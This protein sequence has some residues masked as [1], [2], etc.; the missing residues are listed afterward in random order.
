MTTIH[1][2]QLQQYTQDN[3]CKLLHLSPFLRFTDPYVKSK[4]ISE[5]KNAKTSQGVPH[6]QVYFMF[7][8]DNPQNRLL[9]SQEISNRTTGYPTVS[10]VIVSRS[11][12]LTWS[13]KWKGERS[14]LLTAINSYNTERVIWTEQPGIKPSLWTAQRP[15]FS[16]DF[17]RDPNTDT[18]GTK[19]GKNIPN[20]PHT[21]SKCVTR[22][23]GYFNRCRFSF[24]A[25]DDNIGKWVT[26][27]QTS[28]WNWVLQKKIFRQI[29]STTSAHVVETEVS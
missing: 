7:Y 28:P 24:T 10:E 5:V 21:S 25:D 3:E 19:V 22:N 26:T 11:I 16:Q 27:N 1:T 12:R 17:S 15:Q 20:G 13:L 2:R 18:W 4:D 9:F 23:L 29:F 14:S 8:L 6:L